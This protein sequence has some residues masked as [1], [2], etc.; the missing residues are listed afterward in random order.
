MTQKSCKKCGQPFGGVR[1]AACGKEA[2][3]AWRLA[4]PEKVK[5]AN[6]RRF[7]TN[8]ERLAKR[9]WYESNI[10]RVNE[11]KRALYAA[12]PQRFLKR[13][14]EWRAENPRFV[15]EAVH[16]R[17]AREK[18]VGG[19]LSK[20]LAARLHELQKGKCPCCRKALG[21]K[22]HLDHIIPISKGGA[23]TDDNMQLL[24]STC[25]QQ[26]HAKHPVEFMQSRGFLL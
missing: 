12:N 7:T 4:N 22:Y 19:R 10:L 2:C 8:Q 23:N 6:S 13:N 25:N 17:K 20:G 5:A 24:R 16:N 21:E 18:A 1:C 15:R 11:R 14:A 26:K 9:K 3:R